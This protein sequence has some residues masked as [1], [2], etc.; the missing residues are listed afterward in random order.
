MSRVVSIHECITGTQYL[1]EGAG[2][3]ETGFDRK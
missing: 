1:I 2:L 3:R